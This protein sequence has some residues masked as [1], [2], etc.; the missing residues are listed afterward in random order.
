MMSF[1]RLK[2]A[3]LIVT[4]TLEQAF[5][6]LEPVLG[7]TWN[8]TKLKFCKTKTGN[9]TASDYAVAVNFVSL[10]IITFNFIVNLRNFKY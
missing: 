9:F 7:Q 1:S 10:L 5:Y 4:N 8:N 3:E 2:Q 6:R